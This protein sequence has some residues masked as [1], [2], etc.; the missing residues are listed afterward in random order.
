MPAHHSLAQFELFVLLAIAHLGDEAYGVEIRQEIESRSGREASIGA[1]Y[2]AL[3]RLEDKGLVASFVS[4]PRAVPGG[5][6][7][8]YFHLTP[9]GERERAAATAMLRR[10][11]EGL[12]HA[13]D[14]TT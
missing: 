9:A 11:M 4:E 12:P 13:E 8:K 10:M 2:A 5:R 6:A 1:V 7:R 3:G 14:S